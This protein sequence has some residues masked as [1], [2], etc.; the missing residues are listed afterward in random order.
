MNLQFNAMV[1]QER[2]RAERAE[3]L[4]EQLLRASRAG[5]FPWTHRLLVALGARLVVIG[6]WLQRR[7]AN[8]A[9]S[10]ITEL[11]P[12]EQPAPCPE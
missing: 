9:A 12:P 3:I 2:R 7:Y 8:L 6:T 10:S 11:M 1:E 4:H 5:N